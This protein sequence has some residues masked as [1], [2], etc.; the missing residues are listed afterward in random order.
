MLNAMKMQY[1]FEF[2]KTSFQL[3]NNFNTN[4]PLKVISQIVARHGPAALYTGCSSLVLGNMGKDAVRF[5]AYDAIKKQLAGPDGRTGFFQGIFS[6][7]CAGAAESVLAVTPSECIKTA[8]IDD[9]K[10][11]RGT[12]KGFPDAIRSIVRTQGLKGLY[13]GLLPT[14]IKQAST[15]AV[16]MGSYSF[17][18]ETTE[19]RGI[20]HNSLTTFLMGSIAGVITV[21]TTQPF[22]SIKTR[23]QALGS[24]G[25]VEAFK[26]IVA[27]HGIKG[28][29][30]GSTMRLGR[31]ILGGGIVFTVYEKTRSTLQA[32]LPTGH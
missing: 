7:M 6:G 5:F 21:Y 23:A 4:N 2:A 14:T 10:G 26:S 19:S 15:S 20:E 22:D 29:W 8:L 3:R 27:D 17:M 28:F 30:R 13:R 12:L 18:K 16:R 24:A 32:V 31:L 11:G 25:T 9:A 1:P